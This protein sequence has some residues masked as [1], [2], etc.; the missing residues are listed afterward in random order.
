MKE[1]GAFSSE[2]HRYVGEIVKQREVELLITVGEIAQ[3]IAEEATHLPASK[4]HH[5]TDAEAACQS[6]QDFIEPHDIVLVKGSRAMQMEKIVEV[7][8]AKNEN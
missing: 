5:F 6:V 8:K 2:A 3:E 4:K 7:L 1:L